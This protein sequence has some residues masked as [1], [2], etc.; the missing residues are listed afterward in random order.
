MTNKQVK[1]T[2][3]DVV[4]ILASVIEEIR[5]AGLRVGVREAPATDKRSAGILVFVEGVGVQGDGLIVREQQ[6][7]QADTTGKG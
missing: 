3:A 2:G 6:N 7:N 5:A 4:E 1:L